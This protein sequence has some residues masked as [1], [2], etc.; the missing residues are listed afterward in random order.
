M[1]HLL[2]K[3]CSFR[4]DAPPAARP[5]LIRTLGLFVLYNEPRSQAVF[6]VWLSKEGVDP[7][8]RF[9]GPIEMR[10]LGCVDP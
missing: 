10:T 5:S 4:H 8:T 7:T 2:L 3:V 1:P 6:R 9:A